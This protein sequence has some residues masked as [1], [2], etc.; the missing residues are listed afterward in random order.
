MKRFGIAMVIAVVLGVW[1]AS[2]A[3]A[4]Y[5]KPPTADVGDTNPSP[6]QTTDLFGAH[7]CPNST[8]QIFFDGKFLGTAH[9]DSEGKFDTNITIPSNASAGEHTI[10]VKGLDDECENVREVNITITISGAAAGGN[11]PF[12]GSNISVGA[13]LV[14]ALVIVGAASLVAG[15]RRK[16]TAGK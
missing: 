3:L 12:T 1:A 11:L 10:T 4:F 16:I 2:P 13:L 15:R 7:W 8:V 5:N 9:T 14:I 6:G